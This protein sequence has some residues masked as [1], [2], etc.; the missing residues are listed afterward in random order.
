MVNTLSVL[1][2]G[3]VLWDLLPSGKQMGGAPANF[4]YYA[5]ELGADSNI[6][7]AVGKDELGKEIVCGNHGAITSLPDFLK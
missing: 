2:F 6:I 4:A 5:K 7:S 1:T 3:E